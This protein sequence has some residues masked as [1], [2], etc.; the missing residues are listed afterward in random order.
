MLPRFYNELIPY[1]CIWGGIGITLATQ[2]G[3]THLFAIVLYL[4]GSLIWLMRSNARRKDSQ[5][6]KQ[7]SQRRWKIPFLLYEPYP[8]L[9]LAGALWIAAYTSMP[10]VFVSPV[11]AAYATFL[12][13]KRVINRGHGW[14]NLNEKN[15]SGK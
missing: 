12:L 10:L 11:I 13:W 2:P 6:S 14:F 4:A 5:N 1:I 15:K 9:L 7:V 8:F 3:L